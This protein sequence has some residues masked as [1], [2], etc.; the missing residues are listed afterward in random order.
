MKKPLL[1][2]FLLISSVAFSA[3]YLMTTSNYTDCGP[4]CLHAV[5]NVP[6][7][8][9]E[10]QM[11]WNPSSPDVTDTPVA[12][13]SFLSSQGIPYANRSV[14][15]VTTANKCVPG[16]TVMLIHSGNDPKNVLGILHLQSTWEQHWVVLAGCDGKNISVYWGDNTIKTFT[17]FQFIQLMTQGFP[18]CAYEVGIPVSK[19]KTWFLWFE[20]AIKA[21]F[22]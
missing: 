4:A 10:Q 15:D 21:I 19:P 3:P 7:A 17:I 8:T 18:N 2:L 20:S 5:T 13:F 14:T 6:E 22:K 9:I 11:G 16:K 1:L 12:H